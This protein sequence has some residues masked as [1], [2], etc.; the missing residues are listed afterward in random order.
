MKVLRL[1]NLKYLVI[2]GNH[3]EEGYGLPQ[4]EVQVY[5]LVAWRVISLVSCLMNYAKMLLR[6]SGP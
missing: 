5:V 4:T 1:M 2:Q 3:L 6:L